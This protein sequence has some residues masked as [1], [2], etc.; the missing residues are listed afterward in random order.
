VLSLDAPAVVMLWQWQLG[1]VA[2][3][4][5]GAARVFVLGA[6]VWLAYAADRWFEGW[7]LAPGQ[8]RTQRHQFYQKCR[9]PIASV[10]AAVLAADLATAALDLSRREFCAGLLL[11]VLV[12]FYLLSHQL[13]HRHRAWRAPKEACIALLLGGGVGLFP[14]A[15]PD[16]ALGSLALPLALFTLLCFVNCT[17]ISIWEEAVDEVHG[18]TSLARQFRGRAVFGRALPWVLAGSSLAAGCTL[19]GP[20]RSAAFC[21]AGSSLLLAGVD[22]IERRAGRALARVLADVVLLTPVIPLAASCL[23]SSHG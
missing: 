9:W 23:G 19:A 2:G 6:S 21:V 3:A 18:Q 16:T 14:A 4:G 5:P 1:R 8:I 20:A 7:R 13:V 12:S 17:L 22:R 10:W 11:L 15:R